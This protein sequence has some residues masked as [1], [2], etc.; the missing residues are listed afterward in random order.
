MDWTTRRLSKLQ[1]LASA[2]KYLEI[3]VQTGRTFLSLAF[4]EM[5]GVDPS[6]AFDYKSFVT[7]K[8]RLHQLTSDEFFGQG[9]GATNYDI[10][11]L[12]GLHTYDQTYRDFCNV[13][14]RLHERSLVIIDDVFP[15]DQHS[16]LR[17]QDKCISE[18]MKDPDFS[19]DN[20][21]AW[22]GDVCRLLLFINLFHSEFCYSTLSG[23]ANFQTILWSRSLERNIEPEVLRQQEKPFTEFG[24]KKMIQ[25][26]L[27]NL[28]SI[29]YNWI[30]NHQKLFQYSQE[31]LL[32]NYLKFLFRS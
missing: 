29:D 2:T 8:K 27:W 1:D 31:D 22:H 23:G 14:S 11:F 28:E 4:D 16:M 20:I 30:V 25:K 19:G 17:N 26:A 15:C 5:D 9:L 6:F 24:R 12:D 18:R 10:V 7:S 21:R 13:L 3:G 32:I